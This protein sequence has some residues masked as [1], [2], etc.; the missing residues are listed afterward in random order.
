[1]G[2]EIGVRVA[3]YFLVLIKDVSNG[4]KNCKKSKIYL[5]SRFKNGVRGRVRVAFY[6]WC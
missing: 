6:F 4:C 1:M 3:F 5:K 2:C